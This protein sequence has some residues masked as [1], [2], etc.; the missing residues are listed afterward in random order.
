MG[1]RIGYDQE[2]KVNGL[3]SQGNEGGK[4]KKQL[5]KKKKKTILLKKYMATFTYIC[6]CNKYI[7]AYLIKL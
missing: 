5:E 4:E 3:G 1:V 2:G 7:Y 6:I